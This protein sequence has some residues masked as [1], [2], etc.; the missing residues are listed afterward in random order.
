MTA[1][2]TSADASPMMTI[3]VT[4]LADNIVSGMTRGDS[5]VM[6]TAAVIKAAAEA[7]RTGMRAGGSPAIMMTIAA[8]HAV[9][10]MA[11][12]METAKDIHVPPSS[13]E[14]MAAGR[15]TMTMMT[16]GAVIP[17]RAAA[18]M[19]AG[20]EIPR[21]T[22]RPRAKAGVNPAMKAAVGTATRRAIRRHRVKAGKTVANTVAANRA[23][24]VTTRMIIA[25]TVDAAMAAGPVI[26]RGTAGPHVRVGAIA[27]I[28][29]TGGRANALGFSHIK[30]APGAI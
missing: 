12:G 13:A 10:A 17:H 1:T 9:A 11:A 20:M 26:P 16:A 28:S 2:V 5:P 3:A 14:T 25:A 4:S 15:A 8:V 29:N 18:G 27:D 24:D 23:A 7:V 22:P 19:A 30:P 21:V 6:T